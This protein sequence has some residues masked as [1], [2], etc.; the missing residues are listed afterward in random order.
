MHTPTDVIA[1]VGLR[2]RPGKSHWPA[3][4]DLA[5]S[6]SGLLLGLFMWGHMFFVSTILVSKDF[7]WSVTKAFEGYFFFDRSYPV[8]VSFVVG[9]IA[10]VFVLHA[11]LALRKFPASYRQ[12]RTFTSHRALLKHEDT[13]LWWVQVVTGFALFFLAAP[14]LF[15]MLM[16][17]GAIGPYGSADRVWSA[18]W[19]PLYLVLLL[20]VE[21][22]GGIGLYRL[23]VKWG[24]LQGADAEA[25][26]KRLKTAK[27]ALT[28]FFLVLGLL[29]LA[30]YM[31]IG[32][33][34]RDRVGER[35]TP[36]WVQ[37]QEPAK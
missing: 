5:Q 27:W 21:L 19:W 22:H 7:M 30:A 13:T 29:T 15:Q 16:H 25:G 33:E 12:Y 18:S 32:Y 36:A 34:H 8:L 14:H 1:G 4:M 26:R 17:P 20:A 11:F 35:Y 28:A 23:A 37:P 6:L 2:A 9:G 3:R 10:A 24:W 31:K